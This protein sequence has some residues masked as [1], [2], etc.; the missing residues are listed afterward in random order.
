[1]PKY[2]YLSSPTEMFSVTAP[3]RRTALAM[4]RFKLPNYTLHELAKWMYVGEY[5][6]TA[7]TW[8]Y[9]S[10]EVLMIW[11]VENAKI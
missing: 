3:D 9:T 1:M 5:C 4:F 11:E 8:A 6:E 10:T 2:T 7:I